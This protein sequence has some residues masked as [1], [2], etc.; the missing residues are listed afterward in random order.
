MFQELM[1]L[2][3]HRPLSITIPD[4]HSEGKAGFD[5]KV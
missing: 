3:E 4:F 5:C 1:S 2:I